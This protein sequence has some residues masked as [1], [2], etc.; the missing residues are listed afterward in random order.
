M[1]PKN[2]SS[3][4]LDNQF[5]IEFDDGCAVYRKYYKTNILGDIE[6]DIFDGSDFKLKINIVKDCEEISSHDLTE[7]NV[8]MCILEMDKLS[9]SNK[10]EG[11]KL[12]EATK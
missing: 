4:L 9:A 10:L 11:N 8:K 7:N 12:S 1:I 6:L 2:I 5:R 3:L